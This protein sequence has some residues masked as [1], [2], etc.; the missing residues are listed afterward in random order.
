MVSG[1]SPAEVGLSLGEGWSL[2]LGVG[3]GLAVEVCVHV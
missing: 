1:S 3:A 2:G